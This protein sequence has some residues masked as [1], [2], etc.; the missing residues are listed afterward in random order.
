MEK[1]IETVNA[2]NVELGKQ[3]DE[4]EK[5]KLTFQDSAMQQELS[6]KTTEEEKK[7]LQQE[8][9]SISGS[10]AEAAQQ[11]QHYETWLTESVTNESALKEEITK[12]KTQLTNETNAK[13]SDFN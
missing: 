3:N 10:N 8:L 12:L 6:K 2:N 5:Y 9:A 13:K 11:L 1:K 7:K 4:I